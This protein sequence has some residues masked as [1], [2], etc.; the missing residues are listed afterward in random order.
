MIL[1]VIVNY[2]MTKYEH[3]NCDDAC[4]IFDTQTNKI[5]HNIKKK[6]IGDSDEKL[7]Y[8]FYFRPVYLHC[9]SD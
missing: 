1:T 8:S 4:Y 3:S 6:S 5:I 2:Q 9:R 7:C